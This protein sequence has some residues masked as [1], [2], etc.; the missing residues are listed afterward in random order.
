MLLAGLAVAAALYLAF[1]AESIYGGRDEGVYTNHAIYLATHG[2]LD[3]PY[4]WPQDTHD[5]FAQNAVKFPGFYPTQPTMTVQFG[6]LFS[7][8]LAQAWAT[9]GTVGLFRLNAVFA[10][11]S[12]AVFYGL[13][14]T[15]LPT[16][17]AVAA[18]LFLAFNPMQLWLA[19]ITL[20]EMPT[21]MFVWAGLLTSA[22]RRR[23]RDAAAWAG[24]M[25]SAAS[26]IRL[27]SLLFLP[28]LMLGHAGLRIVSAAGEPA[29]APRPPNAWAAFYATAVP[30]W[31]LALGYFLVFSAPYVA[32]KAYMG[33]LGSAVAA[34]LVALALT[35]PP[36]AP[37][38]RRLIVARPTLVVAG[39]CW[40]GF[41]LWAY[42]I[43]SAPNSAP[44]PIYRWPG[45][46]IDIARDHS[47][48]SLVNLARYL[49]PAVV[50]AAIAGWYITV[51]DVLRQRR[52]ACWMPLLVLVA[53]V[54]AVHLAYPI[55]EDHIWVERRYAPVAIPGFVLCAALGMRWL[56]D[57]LPPRWAPW[58]GGVA[59]V[60]MLGFTVVAD[61]LFFTFAESGGYYAQIARL[62]AQVPRDT[63]VL[64]RGQTEWIT[65]LY[66]SFDRRVVPLNLDPGA[67]GRRVFEA[68]VAKQAADGKPAY[69]LLEGA[70]D[71]RDYHLQPLGE[72][73]LTRVFSE[74]TMDPLPKTI[75]SKQR[76]VGL[77]EVRPAGGK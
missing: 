56:V 25:L 30:G 15:L 3:V 41:A 26:F 36:I 55:A 51:C 73:V 7:T 21:Q 50:W 72:Q 33:Q 22:S 5:L 2:R 52:P 34:A 35:A 6:H 23:A 45:Y 69:L 61:R 54:S 8:W 66:V 27:D 16:P 12:A 10:V 42:W 39:V 70:A 63:L 17:Y 76:T 1:P 18:T 47:R 67:K 77:Y 58:A 44:R 31:L 48:D 65:P 62:A 71:L 20:S 38:L 14:C 13:C 43:R 28:L 68:W 64:A 53:G 46:Y 24:V 60:G 19:R 4:P 29:D 37:H 9:L 74:P 40:F 32:E 59:C 11:L 57:R 49:S 75:I